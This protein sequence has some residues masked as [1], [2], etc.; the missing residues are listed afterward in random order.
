MTA[1]CVMCGTTFE[2]KRKSRVAPIC[3]PRCRLRQWAIVDP[4]R[5]IPSEGGSLWSG[6]SARADYRIDPVTGCWEW[7][8][9]KCP[10]GYSSVHAHRHYWAAANDQEIP[11]GHDIHHRCH[12]TSCVNPDHLELAH[13]RAHD[14]GHFLLAKGR[15]MDDVRAVLDDRRAGMKL[16][17]IVAK[18][19]IPFATI[20]DWTSGKRWP[21]WVT[22]AEP[23]IVRVCAAVDC[24]NVLSNDV[25]H[26]KYC[27]G[28]CC[29]RQNW[30]N[31]RDRAR[32]A[33]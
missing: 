3:S 16:R 8:K 19:G 15:T 5:T 28:T 29:T 23:E 17:A 14:I 9:S 1:T 18:R 11:D 27:S 4:S 13:A 25:M 26:K 30:H 20:Q 33:A 7:L 32:L 22:G 6:T 21:E 12:N 2:R 31:R 10:R 24:S